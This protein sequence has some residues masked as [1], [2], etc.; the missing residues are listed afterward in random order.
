MS[1]LVHHNGSS[2]FG[3][4]IKWVESA[5]SEPDIRVEEFVE[6]DRHVI[7]ADHPGVDPSKDIELTVDGGVLKL[8]G[9]RRAEEHDE[10]RTEIR[11][12]A[13]E[14]ILTLPRG[15]KPEDIT[16]DYANGVLTVS[17]PIA[18]STERRPSPSP[19]T[20]RRLTDRAHFGR[21]GGRRQDLVV[22]WSRC[23]TKASVLAKN[24]PS[25]PVS[26]HLTT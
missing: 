24:R 10:H 4:L 25:W 18:G 7:R 11:Y 17:A 14:R 19:T 2:L 13:F 8:R 9:E 22:G 3:D 16:A 12:G 23:S 1:T 6:G 15:T 5:T 21:P 26:D 20:S